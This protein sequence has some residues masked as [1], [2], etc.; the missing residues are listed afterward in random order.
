MLLDE[1]TAFDEGTTQWIVDLLEKIKQ[2][3]TVIVVTHDKLSLKAKR[4][5]LT[6]PV[7]QAP[8]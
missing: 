4:I 3:R 5:H 8:K 1:P 2:T 6:Y 7:P